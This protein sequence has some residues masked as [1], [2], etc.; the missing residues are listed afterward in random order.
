MTN[1]TET[2]PTVRPGFFN[3]DMV[4][5]KYIEEATQA[6]IKRLSEADTKDVRSVAA[7]QIE[8][9]SEFYQLSLS[10]ASR[11]FRWALV[12]S[13]VGLLFVLAAMLFKEVETASLIG[14]GLIEFIAGVNFYLYGKTLSQ[15]NLFQGRLEVTQRFLVANSLSETL[16]DDYRDKTRAQLIT[17]LAQ[18]SPYN[19]GNTDY[20]RYNRT[21]RNTEGGVFGNN[22]PASAGR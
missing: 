10:Q 3:N 12:A 2:K 7:A 15:L 4:Q 21:E 8:M 17:Q 5:R 1:E 6:S 11:S 9:L 19:S 18:N 22:H 13:V 14:A 20:S 16:G